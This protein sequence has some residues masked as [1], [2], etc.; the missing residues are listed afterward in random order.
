MKKRPRELQLMEKAFG[1]PCLNYSVER[2]NI[3]TIF[4]EVL[5]EGYRI[6]NRIIYRAEKFTISLLNIKYCFSRIR[7]F[8]SVTLKSNL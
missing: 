5:I 1:E 7:F 4:M 6:K 8:V 2:V 3:I